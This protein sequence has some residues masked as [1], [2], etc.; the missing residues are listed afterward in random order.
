[1]SN[2]FY[3]YYRKM[4]Y[5]FNTFNIFSLKHLKYVKLSSLSP[6]CQVY[7]LHRNRNFPGT[8][9]CFSIELHVLRM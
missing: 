7:Y 2:G 6:V 5:I 9:N 3:I 4:V 1:M 8:F